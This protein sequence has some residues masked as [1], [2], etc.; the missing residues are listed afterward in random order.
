MTKLS[1][2]AGNNTLPYKFAITSSGHC[3]KMWRYQRDNQKRM[4]QKKRQYNGQKKKDKM[5]NTDLHITIQETKDWATRT[6]QTLGWTRMFLN[7]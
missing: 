5:T 4:L 7:G 1:K 6:L 3:T 2:V